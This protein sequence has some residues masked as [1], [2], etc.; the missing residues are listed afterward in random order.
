M[1]IRDTW[2]SLLSY[3]NALIAD[4]EKRQLRIL[5]QLSA[6]RH[7]SRWHWWHRYANNPFTVFTRACRL[8][9][10]QGHGTARAFARST[11]GNAQI[12][13]VGR[14][15]KAADDLIAS[16]P[17]H[18]AHGAK[19]EFIHCDATLMT[20]V[21]ALTEHFL[22]RLDKVNFIVTSTAFVSH[23]ARE[24]TSEGIDSKMA[25]LFYA[26]WKIVLDLLP[27]LKVATERGEDTKVLTVLAAGVGGPLDREN[28]GLRKDYSMTGNVKMQV[29]TYTNLVMEVCA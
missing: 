29:P 5:S 9:R 24:E 13:I 8:K 27:L 16:F 18:T 21:S 28:L 20:N 11:N 1:Y 17:K 4:C 19:H 15:Q 12:F 10:F 22:A 7:I 23:F 26:R 3:N 14:N 2:K 6:L 25:L